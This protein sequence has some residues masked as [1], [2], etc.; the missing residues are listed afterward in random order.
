M[1]EE[2][3]AFTLEQRFSGAL[4]YLCDSSERGFQARLAGRL[5]VPSGYI[6]LCSRKPPGFIHGEDVKEGR[7]SIFV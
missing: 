3:E 1:Q 5:G 6:S 7:M 4:S 2:T